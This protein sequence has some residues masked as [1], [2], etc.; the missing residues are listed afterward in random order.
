MQLFFQTRGVSPQ[1]LSGIV[2]VEN[3]QLESFFFA[4]AS[5]AKATLTL[6]QWHALLP[7]GIFFLRSR[8]RL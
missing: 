6:R 2:A 1:T 5:T 3:L 7:T 8:I 4:N